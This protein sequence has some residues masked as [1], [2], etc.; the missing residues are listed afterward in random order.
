[1][2]SMAKDWLQRRPRVGVFELV[3]R[4]RGPAEPYG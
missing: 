3:I 2:N 1:M 4:L